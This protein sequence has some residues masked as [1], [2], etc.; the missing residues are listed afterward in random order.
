MA[1]TRHIYI[2]I[3]ISYDEMMKLYQGVAQNVSVVAR[4][5]RRVQFPASALRPYV[6][7]L[8]VSGSFLIQIDKNNKLQSLSRL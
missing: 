7:S 8:G 2:D 5:G 3:R 4:D 1:Q 6:T